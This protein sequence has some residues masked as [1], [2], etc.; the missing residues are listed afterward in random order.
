[1][2]PIIGGECIKGLTSMNATVR[3]QSSPHDLNAHYVRQMQRVPLLTFDEEYHLA[4]QWRERGDRKAVEKLVASHLRLV[5]KIAAGYR[6]YGLPVS[7]LVS[8][9]NLGMM[10][11]LK[12]YDPERGFRLSTY[13]MWWIKASIQEYIL[14]SWSLVKIG[15]TSAQKKLFFNL[16][17]SKKNIEFQNQD[18]GEHL[19]PEKVTEIARQLSVKEDEVIQMN[20]RLAGH[21]H[22]LNAVI[23]TGGEGE[24]EW[25]EWLVDERD[26]QEI[27]LVHQDEMKKRRGLLDR[28]MEC[29]SQRE[30]QIFMERRLSDPPFTLDELS[31]RHGI[32]RER[33]RQIEVK[34]FEKL[35]KSLKNITFN[36]HENV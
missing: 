4:K 10:Q 25:I 7:D 15:T 30:H 11:A 13:A 34:A 1:M 18:E 36:T 16:R 21:D 9:G 27:A 14:H 35:Q 22:S 28:A 26:N 3:K 8:E 2:S 5:A 31:D 33:V 20:H 19:T 6:G 17:K 24:S 12:H 23:K 32:S 29:L